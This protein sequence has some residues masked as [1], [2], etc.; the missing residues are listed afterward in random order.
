MSTAP[1]HVLV[2]GGGIGGLCLA[3][4]LKQAGVS[5]AVYERDHNRTSR[6]EGYRIHINPAG[7]RALH[8]CL[9]PALWE[10]FVVTSGKPDGGLGFL[11]ERLKELAVIEEKIMFGGT[12]D[13]AEGH[14][15]V[16]RI[17]L[18]RLLLAGLDEVVHFDKKFERYERAPEGRVT[19][20]FADGTS[21][22]G[23]VL[24]GADGASSRVHQQYLP[25]AKRIET[26]AI[27]VGLKLP[28]T[29]QSRAWLPPRL[30]TGMNTVLAPDPCFMFTSVFERKHN[31]VEAIT[32]ISDREEIAGL[33]PGLL[34]DDTQEYQ[35]YVLCAFIAHREAYPPGVHDLDGRGL[36]R[37][38]EQMIEGWHPDL[39]RLVAE[40]DPGS[41]MLVPIKTSVPLDAW[42]ST[43]VTLLGDAI[44]SMPPVGGLG[45]NMALRDANLLRRKLTAVNRGESP[46]LPA[47]HGYEAEML[48]YGF[49]A[50]HASLQNTRQA[51][52]SNRIALAAFKTML[53]I[54][55]AV[56]PLKG[57]LVPE[58]MGRPRR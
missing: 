40:C 57:M 11:T 29:E 52:S 24:V 6:L 14:H 32:V 48:D 25:Q 46:L 23:D 56:P 51:I 22:T 49:A 50:V 53:R 41:V 13:P 39:R 45:G 4:G 2:I 1:L 36:Q 8:E 35:D 17:T 31:W 15:P 20:F 34:V 19:A 38:V 44:H 54:C 18:R 43:N 21:A 26:D 16:D 27:G 55:Q 47:I 9:P 5:V 28:L 3:H 58:H 10:A 42:E 37:L 33:R 30:A 7:S 12:T